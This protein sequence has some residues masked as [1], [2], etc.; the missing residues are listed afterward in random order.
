[1]SSFRKH[2][3]FAL[4]LCAAASTQ[5]QTNPYAGIGRVATQAEL[6]AWD[7]DVRPDFKGL[8]KGNGSVDQG[9]EVWEDKCAS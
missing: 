2:L 5:A 3:I 4:L 6:A 1:M 7:I 9:M 8:P